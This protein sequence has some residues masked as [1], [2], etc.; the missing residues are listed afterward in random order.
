ML[1]S[2]GPIRLSCNALTQCV[3]AGAGVPPALA[4]VQARQHCKQDKPKSSNRA[5][6]M[7]CEP[8]IQKGCHVHCGVPLAVQT[9]VQTHG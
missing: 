5:S 3:Q 1:T 2:R 8:Y 7:F 4:A 6:T 9:A